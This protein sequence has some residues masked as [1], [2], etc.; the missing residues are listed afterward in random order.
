MF[1]G[2]Q[3][4]QHLAQHR[5]AVVRDAAPDL[6]IHRDQDL[7]GNLE[8][9]IQHR[10]RPHVRAAHA[11]QRTHA[12]AGQQR[13]DG[14]RDV[15]HVGADAVARFH[16]RGAQLC[17]KGADLALELR[18]GGLH[19]CGQTLVLEHDGRVTRGVRGFRVA[20]RL[21]RVVDLGTGEP[22]RAGHHRLF[23]HRAVR[24]WRL[25][26]KVLP[27]RRPEAVQVG[28]APAPQSVITV[29]AQAAFAGQPVLVQR[30]ARYRAQGVHGVHA[31]RSPGSQKRQKSRMK[32]WRQKP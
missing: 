9:A 3:P 24:R 31:A 8:K 6:A 28:R 1:D 12:G 27:D 21:P 2:R 32:G 25:D 17:G 11:P 14:G 5:P 29:K 16:A 18:P 30:D 7:G 13:H 4:R 22:H 15:G 20:Q 10:H 26:L 23:Q 19:R